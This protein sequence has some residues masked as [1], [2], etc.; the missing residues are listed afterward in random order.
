NRSPTQGRRH[1]GRAR[2]SDRG[3]HRLPAKTRR[4]RNADQTR[5]PRPTLIRLRIFLPSS[6]SFSFSTPPTYRGGRRTIKIKRNEKEADIS[7]PPSTPPRH[8]PPPHLR[9][10][11]QPLSADLLHRRLDHLR[12]DFPRRAAHE[13]RPDRRTLRASAPRRNSFSPPP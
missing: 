7:F 12:R 9:P 3:P 13:T 4:V 8:V 6:F 10:L 11:G 5:R 1:P 2:P